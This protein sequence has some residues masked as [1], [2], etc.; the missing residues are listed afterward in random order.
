MASIGSQAARRY[1]EALLSAC[2]EGEIETVAA[3]LTGF[4]QATT[5]STD[6]KNVLLNPTFSAEER[7]RTL[8]A[9]MEHMSLGERTRRFITLVVERDRQ[10]ELEG[11]AEAFD[12]LVADK[13]NRATANIV[14]AAQLDSSQQEQLKRALEKR[15]GKKL[16]LKVT[17]DSSLIGGIRAEV[18]GI[19]F[20]G[21]IR[22][23]LDKLRETLR[24]M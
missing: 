16:D 19:V 13:T 15:T 6:L 4:A 2:G 23:E 22:A 12:A 18:S 11:I 7:S 5:E 3:E 14:S 9:L 8:A 20:D 1:A 10:D 24:P 21:S 17:V